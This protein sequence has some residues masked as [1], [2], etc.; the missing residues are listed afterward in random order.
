MGFA[1]GCFASCAR[2]LFTAGMMLLVVVQLYSSVV[3]SVVRCGHLVE[4]PPR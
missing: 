3:A 4:P 1:Q 2:V